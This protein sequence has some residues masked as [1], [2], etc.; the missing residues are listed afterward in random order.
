MN[1]D[2][3][4]FNE[5]T[6]ASSLSRSAVSTSAFLPSA[7]RTLFANVEIFFLAPRT[8]ETL[9]IIRI[10]TGA[11]LCYIH[12]IWILDLASFFGANSLLSLDVLNA[13]HARAYKWTYLAGT[14]SLALA[15]IHEILAAI[16]GVLLAVGF[17]TRW[18]S[19]TAWFLTLMTVHRLTPF[20]FGL[21]QIT[22]MLALYLCIG[23][24][25]SCWSI[26]AWIASRYGGLPTAPNSSAPNS[27]APNSSV[28]STFAHWMAWDD[29]GRA[30]WRN[31][32]ATRLLQLHLCVVYF[33]GGLGK[34]RG[35][36]WWDGTAMWFSAASYEY[37]SLDL[38]WIGYYPILGALLTH[39]TL[40]WEVTY[41][42]LVWPR[43]TRPVV[44]MIAGVVHASIAIFLGM[45]TFGAMMI[46]A[47]LAFIE[48]E[49]LKR[50]VPSR[51]A[52]SS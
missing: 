51:I 50:C 45:I 1:K 30:C 5:S 28:P 9:A 12:C 33:F 36:M 23:R 16:A 3:D 4:A 41:C 27:S 18:T 46:V 48:P 49:W 15:F 22:L 40:F 37:Q 21:D 35:G 32:L 17:A 39:V 20:L 8:A 13:L 6:T 44:L 11:M 43:I 14:D 19:V 52:K 2:H 42:A 7:L 34:L 47:N 24:S 26:D 29:D 10:A 25:G 31:T 38:T